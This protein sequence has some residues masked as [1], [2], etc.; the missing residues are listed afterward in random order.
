VQPRPDRLPLSF[1]QERIWFLDRL[2]PESMAQH[3][4]VAVRVRG[5]FD[6]TALERALEA[7]AQRHS[8]LRSRFPSIEGRPQQIVSQAASIAVTRI[9][10]KGLAPADRADALRARLSEQHR[11][12]FDLERDPPIRVCL[13]E[14]GSADQVLAATIHHIAADGWA[15]GIFVREL[16]HLYRAFTRAQQPSLPALPIQYADF[17]A[18]QRATFEM[19]PVQAQ[20]R[21]WADTLR[22]APAAI[23]LPTDR[24]RP[25]RMTS[26]AAVRSALVAKACAGRLVAVARGR[27]ATL[28]M[29]LL[30]AL[31][32]VLFRWTGQGDLV[33]GTVMGSRHHVATE[34]LIGCFMNVLPLRSTL[35]QADSFAAVLERCRSTILQAYSNLD[36]P[37]EKI[38]E[39]V[40]PPRRLNQTPL[41]N[42]GLLLQ[43]YPRQAAAADGGLTRISLPSRTAQLDLRFIAT[44]TDDGISLECEYGTELFE[45]ATIAALLGFYAGVLEQVGNAPDLRLADVALP[46]AL[47]V[48]AVM[49]GSA[50][51]SANNTDSAIL[52]LLAGIESLSEADAAIAP[53][54]ATAVHNAQLR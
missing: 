36:C 10:L 18:W 28:F 16:D 38:I 32:V 25:A 1:A 33:V 52:E 22:G 8:V 29:I 49:S 26:A 53:T 13:F 44:E 46:P 11:R 42:V 15:L 54:A 7:I 31:K 51:A 4:P 19:E 43:N 3:L 6:V 23:A 21:Y 30:A 34:G 20:L 2:F 17:A 24:L 9:D 5:P 50:S 45:A 39:A 48:Q 47:A 41:Y 12:R 35:S 27:S 14:L 37:F 40:N